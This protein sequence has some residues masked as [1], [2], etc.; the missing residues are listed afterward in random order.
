MGWPSQWVRW[1]DWW[2]LADRHDARDA[3]LDLWRR[4]EAE[5]VEAASAKRPVW[6]PLSGEQSQ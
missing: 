4:A 5:R 1:P 2:L 3:L 6:F